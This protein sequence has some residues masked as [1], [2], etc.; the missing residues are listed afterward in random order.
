MI[1]EL[2]EGY[3]F[4][5]FEFAA[6]LANCRKFPRR[7]GA[8]WKTFPDV[9]LQYPSSFHLLGDRD[10]RAQIHI[11]NRIQQLQAFVHR[12]LERLAA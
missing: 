9:L 11:L 1:V 10:F 4:S 6:T 12:P 2:V 7:C 8:E 3:V 5:A